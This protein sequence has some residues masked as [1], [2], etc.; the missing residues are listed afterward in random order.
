MDSFFRWL[1]NRFTASRKHLELKQYQVFADLNDFELY[2]LNELIHTRSFKAGELIYEE[3]YPLEVIYFV[4]SG[5]IELSGIYGSKLNKTVGP[6]G[7][8]GILDMYHGNQRSSTATAKTDIEA[9]V[10]SKS[11]LSSFVELKPR[12]GLK[13]LSAINQEFCHFIFDLA[14]TKEHELD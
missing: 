4:Q 13:I 7:H 8:L 3:G 6:G 2:L 11:D 9:H 12:A 14:G 10:I 5:E 1:K